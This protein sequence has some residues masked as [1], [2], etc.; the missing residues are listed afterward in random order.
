M[1][2]GRIFVVICLLACF[3]VATWTHAKTLNVGSEAEVPP[4]PT[5]YIIAGR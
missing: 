5:A 2:L 1:K 3:L 4:T